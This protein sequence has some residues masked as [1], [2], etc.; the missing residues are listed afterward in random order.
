MK[1]KLICIST[2]TLLAI[3]PA[4]LASN[5]YVDGKHGSDNNNCKSRQH[6]CKTISNALLLT[7]PGILSS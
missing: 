6:A 2:L 7:L 4:A 5:W 3:V 1:S